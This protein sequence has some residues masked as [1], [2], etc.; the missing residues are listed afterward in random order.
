[1]DSY[2]FTGP[3]YY[4]GTK[5]K[6]LKIASKEDAAFNSEVKDGW[7][8][9]LQHHFVAAIIPTRDQTHRFNLRV[10]DSEYLIT[11]LGPTMTLQPGEGATV[12]QTL[13]VGPKLQRQLEA[14]HPE[15]GRAADFGVLTFLSRPLFWLLDKAHKVFNNWGLAII[16]I[17]F[18]LK[19]LFY[20]LAETSG[21]SMAKMKLIAPRM[22]VLQETYKDDRRSWVRRPWSC[23]RK[24]R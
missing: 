16:S 17:T 1:M 21:R 4:D 5:Y 8:A 12:E 13:F 18:L 14:I 22:K 24:R 19:L 3:A 15:L 10:R 7:I 11:D 9:S 23:T 6:K 2:S 20:P